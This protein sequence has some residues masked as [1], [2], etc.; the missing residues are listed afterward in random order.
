MNRPMRYR[1]CMALLLLLAAPLRTASAHAHL[2]RSQPA[3]DARVAAPSALS[4]TFSEALT[5]A[6]CRV[7]LVDAAGNA[8]SLGTVAADSRDIKTLSV[9]IRTALAPGRYV[10]KWQVAGADG[11][12]ARGQF[13]FDVE[14]AAPGKVGGNAERRLLLGGAAFA[15]PFMPLMRTLFSQ[16]AEEADFTVESPAYV[17]VRAVQ[18]TALVVLL[19]VLSLHFLIVPRAARRIADAGGTAIPM[20]E[21]LGWATAALLLLLLVTCTRLAAQYVAFFGVTESPTRASV[22]ALLTNSMW[23][24]GWWLALGSTI[25]GLWST[26][27]IRRSSRAGWLGL[28]IS[29]GGFV[30][31]LALSGHAAASSGLAMAIHAL[32][33]LGA[34]GW[35]GSL[36]AVMLVAVP[37]L[38]RAQDD[39]RDAHLAALVRAFSPIALA[40]AGVIAGTGVLAAS[41][42]LGSVSALWQARY[43]QV[44]L[45]KMAVLSVTAATGFYNWRAVQP[46]LSTATATARLRRSATIELAAALLVLMVT[47]VLVATPM[48][49]EMLQTS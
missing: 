6:L 18:S 45:V 10:V 13:A 12:P 42:N 23:A 14:A 36:A 16:A 35:I 5:V 32:H 9:P 2:V 27:R 41:R 7:S 37:T 30:L 38:A 34:G 24:Y 47:A 19:G 1:A 39:V 11:H 15:F 26:R 49:V 17:V 20:P 25:G 48:P 29:A 40:C 8:V 43:G 31:S 28:A 22:H 46:A 21:G 33:V 3:A 44:L 4:L